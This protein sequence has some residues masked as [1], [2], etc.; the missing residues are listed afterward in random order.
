MNIFEHH[1]AFHISY[2]PSVTLIQSSS[3]NLGPDTMPEKENPLIRDVLTNTSEDEGIY[4]I[5]MIQIQIC[6]R[7][8]MQK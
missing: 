1:D 2:V 5:V 6:K 3:V 4:L 8:I 7:L